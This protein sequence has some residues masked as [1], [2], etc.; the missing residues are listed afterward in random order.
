MD[1]PERIEDA[2]RKERE[3]FLPKPVEPVTEP[4]P[5]APIEEQS[6]D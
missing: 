3:T 4:E 6:D 1:T 2:P 5:D